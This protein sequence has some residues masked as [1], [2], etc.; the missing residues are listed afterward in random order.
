MKNKSHQ[1][2]AWCSV[3]IAEGK[4]DAGFPSQGFSHPSAIGFHTC[5]NLIHCH[6]GR[7]TLPPDFAKCGGSRREVESAA[8][9]AAVQVKYGRVGARPSRAEE[10]WYNEA[11]WDTCLGGRER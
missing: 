5:R 9:M 7:V 2:S 4:Q 11:A 8:K 6:E 10:F 1:V 3:G